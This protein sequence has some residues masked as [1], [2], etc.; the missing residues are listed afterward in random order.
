[1]FKQFKSSHFLHMSGSHS[2]EFYLHMQFDDLHLSLQ[3]HPTLFMGQIS[4]I[5]KQYLSQNP[6]LKHSQF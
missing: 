1:M 2:S 5:H 6:I 3:E 4:L